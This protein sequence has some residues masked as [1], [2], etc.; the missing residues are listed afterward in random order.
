MTTAGAACAFPYVVPASALGRDGAVAPSNRLVMGAIGVGGR[1]HHDLKW[2]AGEAD[3]QIVAVC[4]VRRERRDLGKAVVDEKYGNRD[5]A[6]FRDFRD[7]LEK[8]QELD[9]VLIAIGDRWHA[10]ASIFCMRAGKDVYSE[11][12]GT[13]TIAEGQAL[14]K[15]QSQYERVFQT[16][17]QRASESNFVFMGEALRQGRL[18]KVHTVRAHLGYLTKW[19]RMN[20]VLPAEPLPPKEE[21][22]WDLWLGQCPVRPYNA[23]FVKAWPAPG[24]YTQYDFAGSIAAWG[25]H[26]ILQCQ[27]DLGLADTS[28]VEY[29]YPADLLKDGMTVRFANGVKLV[30]QLEGWRG[31]CGVRYEGEEGWIAC[32]DGYERPEVSSPA[33]LDN[34]VTV[35]KAYR[36]RTGR[37]NNHFRDFLQSVK[38]RKP[39]ITDAGVAHRTMTTNLAMDICLDLKRHVK[40]DPVNETF[41]NDDEA[42]TLRSRAMRE[43]WRV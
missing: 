27:L 43:P 34:F 37:P 25:S 28:A 32:A 2:L 16:G 41:V 39:T 35:I 15:A 14:V 30:A 42:N 17:A 23:A 20:A 29:E 26:T 4:D 33:L 21:L 3:V 7:L 40:W 9:A 22:D 19:P 36:E 8:K 18:G 31:S 1:G 10:V 5:C 11:K 12:P 13:L 38:S 24:W 6:T